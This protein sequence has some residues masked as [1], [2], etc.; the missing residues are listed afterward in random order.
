VA[1]VTACKVEAAFDR[2]M[3]FVFDL[4]G[5]DFTQD[6]LFGEVFGTNYYAVCARGAAGGEQSN[7]RESE[8]GAGQMNVRA[9]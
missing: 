1:N 8:N 7:E 6:E 3:S 4:L 5:D 2:E 9:K